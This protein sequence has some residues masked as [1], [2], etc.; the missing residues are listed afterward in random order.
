MIY[1][2]KLA[3]HMKWGSNRMQKNI[4]MTYICIKTCANIYLYLSI[5][6]SITVN[7]KI[8]I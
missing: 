4:C 6:L 1:L 2:S 7:N 3:L 5:Y 8:N